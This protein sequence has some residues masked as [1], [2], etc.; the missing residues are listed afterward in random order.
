[1]L[2]GHVLTADKRRTTSV[3]AVDAG[4][5]DMMAPL[6]AA[7]YSKAD[8][9]CADARDNKLCVIDNATGVPCVLGLQSIQNR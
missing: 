5:C 6:E 3:L 1:M 2:F 7:G 9:V 8:L 4:R